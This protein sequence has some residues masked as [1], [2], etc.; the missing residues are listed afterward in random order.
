[1]SCA[2]DGSAS[3]IADSRASDDMG[4]RLLSFV[5]SFAF[6]TVFIL[7]GSLMRL[8]PFL[9]VRRRIGIW[10]GMTLI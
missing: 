10:I 5:S 9:L 6:I 1:M 7:M 8:L 2:H 4:F 3:N